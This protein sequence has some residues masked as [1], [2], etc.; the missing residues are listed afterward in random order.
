MHLKSRV[1]ATV[2]V[3]QAQE[4]L[5]D[6]IISDIMTPGSGK[7]KGFSYATKKMYAKRIN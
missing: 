4:Y 7:S 2:G 5:P 1:Y 6:L 3:Q